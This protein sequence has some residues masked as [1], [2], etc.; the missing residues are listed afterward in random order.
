[1]QMISK[2]FKDLVSS[3]YKFLKYMYQHLLNNISNWNIY[4][5]SKL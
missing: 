2:V 4:R 3:M 1:M 5:S